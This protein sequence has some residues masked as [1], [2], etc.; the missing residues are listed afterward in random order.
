MLRTEAVSFRRPEV[1]EEPAFLETFAADFQKVV[2]ELAAGYDLEEKIDEIEELTNLP[3]IS[4]TIR[5][6]HTLSCACRE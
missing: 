4:T 6:A 2:I 1:V 3:K 5:I